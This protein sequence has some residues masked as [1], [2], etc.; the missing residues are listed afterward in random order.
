MR[1]ALFGVLMATAFAAPALA[2]DIQRTDEAESRPQ[3]ER[4][5]VQ[6]ERQAEREAARAERQAEREAVRAE[7]QEERAQQRTEAAEP[8]FE[9]RQER[10]EQRVEAAERAVRAQERVEQ[11]SDVQ[12]VFRRDER[13]DRRA[14]RQQRAPREDVETRIAREKAQRVYPPEMTENYRRAWDRN[15]AE[16]ARREE[17]QLRRQE[18]QRHG[19]RDQRRGDWNNGGDWNGDGRSWS[20]NRRGWDRGWRNDRRYDWQRHR[21]TNRSIFRPGP[22]YSPYRNYGYN[23]FS[24]GITLGRDFYSNRYWLNDPWQYR[25]PQPYPGTRW[26]RYYNDVLL[27]DVFDGRVLDVIYD[28]FW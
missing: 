21:Y 11:R 12:R 18:A 4:E 16:V 2:Q 20:D 23:R 17:Q 6:V 10:I 13:E 7:R 15:E 24:I 3:L 14:D 9:R 1:R 8:R 27:V 25:L 28:F 22:Y 19:R 5:Q 26:V